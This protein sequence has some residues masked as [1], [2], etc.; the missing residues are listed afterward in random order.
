MSND[1]IEDQQPQLAGAMVEMQELLALGQEMTQN[2]ET[3]VRAGPVADQSPVQTQSV[4]RRLGR[5][6]RSPKRQ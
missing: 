4:P 3:E 2:L 1:D 6:T 5:A